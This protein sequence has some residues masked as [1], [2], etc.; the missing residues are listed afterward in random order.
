M[1]RLMAGPAV[2]QA[3]EP[4]V[5][6]E[7]RPLGRRSPALMSASSGW[8]ANDQDLQRLFGHRGVSLEP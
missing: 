6:A 2:G 3:H 8:S 5:M 7:G 4:D 1:H